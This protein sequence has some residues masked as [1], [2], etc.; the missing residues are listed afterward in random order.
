M[1]DAVEQTLDLKHSRSNTAAINLTSSPKGGDPG[2]HEKRAMVTKMTFFG[3][4]IFTV[5]RRSTN[6]NPDAPISIIRL[7]GTLI[8]TTCTQTK[9]CASE[10]PLLSGRIVSRLQQSNLS[11]DHTLL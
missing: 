5:S 4:F 6:P 11:T 3:R 7:S 10:T 9:C 2:K 1:A 8:E